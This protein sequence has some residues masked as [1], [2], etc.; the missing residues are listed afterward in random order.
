MS[1]NS[2]ATLQG[3]EIARSIAVQAA[4]AKQKP[5][6]HMNPILLKPKSDVE[7][8]VI[9]HGK[10]VADLTAREYYSDKW[11]FVKEQ[12][13]KTSIAALQ[14]SFDLIIAEGAGSCAEP[15]FRKN[16]LVNMGIAHILDADVFLA[17]DIDRGG[18]FAEILGTL[19]ILDTI[20]PQDRKRIKGIIINR[21][22]GDPE[23]LQPALDF[24][25]SHTQIPIA[26]VFPYISALDIEEEDR[27]QEFPCPH[28]EIDIAVVYLPHIANASD[29]NPLTKQEKLR[30][31]FV[32]SP[33][34]LGAPDMIILPGSKNTMWDLDYIK[35]IG[36]RAAL[37]KAAET[38]P[39]MGIC[40][41]FEMLGEGLEDPHGVESSFKK[42]DGLGFFD[43]TV[44]FQKNKKVS[45]V[46]YQPSSLSPFKACGEISGYEIH[47]GSILY[48]KQGSSLFLSE[49]HC[50]GIIRTDPL[51]FGTFI[52]DIFK[53]TL[54]TQEIIN[55]LRKK[56]QL[57]LLASVPASS[58]DHFEA[59]YDLL[60]ETLKSHLNISLSNFSCGVFPSA[61]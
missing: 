34:T 53:N 59:Q 24:I 25:T 54:F 57:P 49:Q 33:D 44:R 2:Y 20:A 7:S 40:G 43:F 30:V 51:V 48:G 36:W 37:H 58:E 8:Q 55:M 19:Q 13:I 46:R 18:V 21:F 47:C 61:L 38:T 12:A 15:N 9:I 5:L 42:Q 17:V 11:Y 1:L 31:R 50:D 26:A 6:V 14:D 60:A 28:P 52:H 39:L 3:E 4:A 32:R 10:A 29:F 56:K 45:Q 23:L 27:L 16:D 35:R 22:R 41:G